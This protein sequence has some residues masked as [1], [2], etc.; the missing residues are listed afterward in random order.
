MKQG[1]SGITNGCSAATDTVSGT[2]HLGG[3]VGMHTGKASQAYQFW[4]ETS[5]EGCD[6]GKNEAQA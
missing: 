5:C 6:S 4:Y 2:P 1:S 3:R